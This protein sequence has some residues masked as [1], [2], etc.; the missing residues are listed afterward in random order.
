MIT[1]DYEL[2]TNDYCR[3]VQK[4]TFRDLNEFADWVFENCD[5]EYKEKISIPDP[6][7][8]I[9]RPDELPYAIEVNR[10]WTRNNHLWIHQIKDSGVIIFS[11]GKHT[12]RTKHWNETVKSLCRTMLARRN[13][14]VFNFG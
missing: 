7:G 6:D 3:K 13:N 12:N 14:P 2:Y 10:M 4:E 1:V 8:K 11:D 9:F 5:G